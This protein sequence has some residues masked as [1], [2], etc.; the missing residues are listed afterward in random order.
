MAFETE[1]GTD[2]AG[3]LN[4]VYF[5]KVAYDPKDVENFFII[6]ETLMAYSG[7]KSQ[8]TKLNCLSWHLP[9]EVQTQF[10]GVLQAA[11]TGQQGYK[12]YKHA[13]LEKFG[14]KPR[15]D[16]A[17]TA[18][19]KIDL[20]EDRELIKCLQNNK[21]LYLGFAF[22]QIKKLPKIS[23]LDQNSRGNNAKPNGQVERENKAAL[24]IQSNWKMALQRQAYLCMKIKVIKLQSFARMVIQ[25]TKY[26]KT[27]EAALLIQ[28]SF[29]AK[30]DRHM[31]LQKRL[32]SITLQSYYRRHVAQKSYK[33]K[34]I[35]AVKIQTAWRGYQA[36]LRQIALSDT[37]HTTN[38]Q[39]AHQVMAVKSSRQGG[40]TQ[41]RPDGASA[42]F[43]QTWG[44]R[45]P[46]NP[47]D[48]CC[49]VHWRLDTKAYFCNDTV[50]CPLVDTK[51][52]FSSNIA[53]CPWVKGSSRGRN[54]NRM[55][56]I[57]RIDR[58]ETHHRSWET[59]HRSWGTHH[60]LWETHHR[61]WG[62]HRGHG[63]RTIQQQ[64]EQV[65][66]LK[67]LL[68]MNKYRPNWTI[69]PPASCRIVSALY[70]LIYNSILVFS[71]LTFRMYIIL[72]N[73]IFVDCTIVKYC[74]IFSNRGDVW[75]P[76]NPLLKA[77]VK[78][79]LYIV[80]SAL[81][82]REQSQQ[83]R[84]WRADNFPFSLRASQPV[85]AFMFCAQEST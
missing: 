38:S 30:R 20:L 74:A 61:S 83:S 59:H 17:K 37:V 72:I 7:I 44:I 54:R 23:E 53:N 34:K 82:E 26:L 5:A 29:R 73:C 28:R 2:E 55:S 12:Q 63:G 31:F 21:T 15:N 3:A 52:Y 56:E 16:F 45:H 67:I 49:Q 4:Y 18:I 68:K 10:I 36:R 77:L 71:Q 32:A 11:A 42:Q 60:R 66:P 78:S 80:N 69:R 8:V 81:R 62:T 35:A 43:P 22:D 79:S 46:D 27:K 14:P 58:R 39:R 33:E 25:R 1:N 51:A 85:D 41:A 70:I 65:Y 40:A 84:L 75:K 13:I 50:N 9:E 19:A 76:G 6:L 64:Q 47:P 24:V 48:G 57:H